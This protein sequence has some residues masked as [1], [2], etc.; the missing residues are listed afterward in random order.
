[1]IKFQSEKLSPFGFVFTLF[2]TVSLSNVLG[3]SQESHLLRSQSSADTIYFQNE[4]SPTVKK[5]IKPKTIDSHILNS[6]SNVAT[7]N[8]VAKSSFSTNPQW[9]NYVNTSSIRL[10]CSWKE[11]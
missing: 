9:I 2:I 11:Q 8:F 6:L 3:Y 5:E 7:T 4:A 1:M 10:H